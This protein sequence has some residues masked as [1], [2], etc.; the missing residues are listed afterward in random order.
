MLGRNTPARAR[1]VMPGAGPAA[2]LVPVVVAG[3][4]TSEAEAAVE[5]A[6]AGEATGEAEVEPV[7]GEVALAG[8][9]GGVSVMALGWESDAAL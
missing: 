7:I 4:S 6:A 9:G 1:V 2:A 5:P 3:P 8:V